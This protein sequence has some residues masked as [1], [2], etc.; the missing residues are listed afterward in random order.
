MQKLRRQS[1]VP[2]GGWW[3]LWEAVPVH[4]SSREGLVAAITNSIIASGKA[5]PPDLDQQIENAI[6][7]RLPANAKHCCPVGQADKPKFTATHVKRFMMTM[8]EWAKGGF[9]YVPQEEADRRAKICS[10]CPKNVNVPG[11]FG[12]K[13]IQGLVHTLA[14]GHTTEYDNRLHVCGVCGCFNQTQIWFEADVLKRASGEL[15][16]PEWCWK[17]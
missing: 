14:S 3:C 17:R 10:E 13:G 6:C 5:I 4:A 7:E 1:K 9:Q 12:C 11:C 16:Y 15:D 8:T 2:P